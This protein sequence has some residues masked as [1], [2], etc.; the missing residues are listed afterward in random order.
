[1]KRLTLL[2]TGILLI[3]ACSSSKNDD[4]ATM[5]QDDFLWQWIDS[6]V[7]PGT[8]FFKYATGTWMKNNPI[9]ESEKR[10]G[11]ANLVRDDNYTKLRQLSEEAANDKN[12]TKGSNAQKIGDF[13]ATGMDSVTIETQGIK[14]LQAE[15]DKIN[16]LKNIQDV[17]SL[18]ADY[19][20]KIGSPLI[21]PYIFQDEMN[22]EKYA[23]HFY[24]GG[25]GLPDRDYYF[26]TDSRTSNIRKEYILHLTKMFM[27]LGED[28]V[29]SNR[30]AAAVMKIETD[31]AKA[32]R[33]LEEMRDPYANYNKMSVADFSKLTP[34][35]SWPDFFARM[36]LKNIDTVIVGQPE[37]YR[38]VEKCLKSVSVQDWQT[39]L[40]WN[41]INSFADQLSS[42][43]D[44][45]NFHFYG[46]VMSGVKTQRPRWKRVL[47]E[48]ENFLG[49]ALGQLYVA[50][51]VSSG[52][53]LRYDKLVQNML[54][55]YEE[56][57]KGLE[58]MGDSTKQKAIAKLSKINRKVCY[59]DKWKDYSK[60]EIS[61]DSYVQNVMNCRNWSHNYYV[62]KLYKPVDRNEWEMTPQ[63]YNAYY[64][65]SNNEI[66]LPA[67]QFLIPGL[68]DSLADDA[69]IYGYAAA[70]TIGHEL[71]HGFDD[72]G[73]QFDANGNLMNWWTAEDSVKFMKQ[74]NILVQQF[75]D[76]VVLDSLHVN[77]EASLG[78]NIADLGGVVIGLEAFKKTE[79]YKKGEK[80]DGLTPVQRYFL[81]YT[82]GWLGHARDASLAMQVMT[83]VHAPNFLRVNGPLSNVPEFYDAFGIK[84]GDPMWRPDSLRVK[85]W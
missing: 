41:L 63:T 4:K 31:L 17:V 24:Q 34:S 61:R 12:A 83:D 84:A 19:Q 68:P 1:M 69:I 27:L 42:A 49:D 74:A 20:I 47:D 80:I 58:W 11:I 3:W 15:L 38:Q 7:Q 40:R 65:P 36:N 6:T 44:K 70:S 35:I 81:G 28:G 14:P 59:P 45:Q 75:S 22:S 62:E 25:I 5:T 64:N 85:I 30:S 13:W 78:E 26:N 21:S 16:A 9:P 10:W 82:L 71:T 39:Y 60:L 72:Q 23:L 2:I 67:A 32:S 55:T 66:V 46:T 56:R 73:R 51:Y 18:I 8:D 37:F 50:K 52:M 54:E 57:I 48:Q 33:K 53:R 79:Q 29:T 77:G 76:Y 43:F